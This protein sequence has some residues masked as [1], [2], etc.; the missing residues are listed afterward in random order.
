MIKLLCKSAVNDVHSVFS[1]LKT[2]GFGATFRHLNSRDAP[3]LVQFGKYGICGVAALFTQMAIF[4]GLSH[5]PF[6]AHAYLGIEGL[7]PHQ[8]QTNAIIANVIA[9]PFANIVAYVLNVIWVF[10]P[11]K[12]SRLREFSLFTLI[13][14]M[15]FGVGLFGGPYFISKGLNTWVAQGGFAITSALVNYVCR[16]VLIFLK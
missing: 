2:E 14:F 3:G 1:M 12:H 5:G 7:T 4:Y 6:P 15:A 8:M 10:T 9:F 16:K 13:A 11:G